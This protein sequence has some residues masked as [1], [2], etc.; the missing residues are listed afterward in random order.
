VRGSSRRG[1]DARGEGDVVPLRVRVD[2]DRLYGQARRRW[3]TG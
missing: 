2:T 3:R 1:G